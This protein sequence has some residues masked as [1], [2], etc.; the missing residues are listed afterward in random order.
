MRIE[1]IELRRIRLPYRSPFETSGW[2]E[3]AN[4]SGIVTLHS[5][6]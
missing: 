3:E 5:E 1:A 4:H 6:G 2:R